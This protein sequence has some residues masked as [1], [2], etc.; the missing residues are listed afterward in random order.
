MNFTIREVTKE[1][2]RNETELMFKKVEPYLKD[3]Y[4]LFSALREVMGMNPP[5]SKRWYKDLKEY[6]WEQGYDTGRKYGKG[7]KT[8]MGKCYYPTSPFSN[9]FS[10]YKTVNYEKRYFGIVDSEGKAKA[11]VQRL[12][13]INWDESQFDKIKKEFGV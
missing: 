4:G 5:A 11:I 7:Y 9:R 6:C 10:I 1:E 8:K 12:N 3:G 2:S 13:Q